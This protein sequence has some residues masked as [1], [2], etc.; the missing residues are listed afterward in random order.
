MK[1][2]FTI[3]L[4]ILISGCATA[5]T[6]EGSK[7][8]LVDNQAQYNCKF[9]GTVTGSNSLGNTTAHDTDGALNEARNKASTLGA[10]ALRI[11]NIDTTPETTTV[12]AEA[13]NCE[14]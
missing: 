10:N 8:R 5:L 12:A 1:L 3:A 4:M 13:L 9:V 14:F 11:L 7:V 2:F 6:P